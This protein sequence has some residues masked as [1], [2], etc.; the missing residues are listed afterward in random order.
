MKQHCKQC[1]S[2]GGKG[3][4]RCRSPGG[5]KSC[6]E[7]GS[8]WPNPKAERQHYKQTAEGVIYSLPFFF[9]FFFPDFRYIH[10]KKSGKP[11]DVSRWASS[12]DSPW[13]SLWHETAAKWT[14]DLRADLTTVSRADGFLLSCSICNCERKKKNTVPE[15][16]LTQNVS[17]N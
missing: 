14:A 5:L 13:V 8:V 7:K 2:K 1:S 3:K 12:E 16:L 4:G 9:F 6:G 17:N 10:V 15:V 11:P